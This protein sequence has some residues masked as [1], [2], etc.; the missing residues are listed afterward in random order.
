MYFSKTGEFQEGFFTLN[1][2]NHNKVKVQKIRGKNKLYVYI[3]EF[4]KRKGMTERRSH[5][6]SLVAVLGC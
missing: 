4:D 6:Y 1:S 2:A 3:K 5:S